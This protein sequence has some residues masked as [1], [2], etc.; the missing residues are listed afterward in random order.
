MVGAIYED[1]LPHKSQAR[2]EGGFLPLLEAEAVE[3]LSSCWMCRC[4]LAATGDDARTK[5]CSEKRK[6]KDILVPSSRFCKAKMKQFRTLEKFSNYK[7]LILS[8]Y[9]VFLFLF[10]RSLKFNWIFAPKCSP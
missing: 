5:I 7:D 9:F 6:E 4:N 10:E 2:G 1:L 8:S 3:D